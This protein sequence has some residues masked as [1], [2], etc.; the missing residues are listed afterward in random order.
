L[1]FVGGLF[2]AGFIGV[3]SN[4]K[5]I[6]DWWAGCCLYRCEKDFSAGHYVDQIYLNLM[7]VYFENV[8]ILKHQ[9]CNVANWNQVVCKREIVAG[10]VRINKKWEIVFLHFTKS[11]IVGILSGEDHLLTPHLNS[12]LAALSQ[13]GLNLDLAEFKEAT[14]KS[15]NRLT[16]MIKA[17][18]GRD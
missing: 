16:K 13:H 15:T 14:A 8:K 12:Y 17:M 3:K 6:M 5:H 18:L 9:G 10:E 11:T 7:P 2:N 4:S 1:Q